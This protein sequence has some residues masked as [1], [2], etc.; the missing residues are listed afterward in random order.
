MTVNF[1]LPFRVRTGGKRSVESVCGVGLGWRRYAGGGG[2]GGLRGMGDSADLPGE[3]ADKETQ[4]RRSGR[5]E[6]SAWL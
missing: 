3:E 5:L 1:L 6:I 2:G 4:R